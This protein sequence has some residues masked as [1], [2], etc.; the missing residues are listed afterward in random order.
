MNAEITSIPILLIKH[1]GN[2][3]ALA[4]ELHVNRGTLRNYVHDKDCKHHVIINGILMTESQ[5]K[6]NQEGIG[7]DEVRAKQGW[8][9]K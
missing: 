4:R 3:S 7:L 8:R 2:Q 6:G 5:K 1:R 9:H